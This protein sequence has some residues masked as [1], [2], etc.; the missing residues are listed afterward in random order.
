M[1]RSSSG[2]VAGLTV[3]AIAA[4]GFLAFQASANVPETLGKPSASVSAKSSA[5][6]A[7]RDKKNPTALPSSSGTGARVV[8]SVGD[9]RVWLV[10]SGNKVRRTFKVTPGTVDPAA[11]TYAVTTRAGAVTGSDGT[12]IEHVVRFTLVNG[13]AIGFSAAV[14]GST[15]APDPEKKLGGIR[16]SR[17]DG[18]A[19]WAFATVGAKVVVIK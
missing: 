5:P 3:A 10:G 12:Q 2:F 4:V 15:E 11:G 18:D 16:A 13:V 6:K 8:Y 9:D 1:A 7:P 17:A 19:M 14:N